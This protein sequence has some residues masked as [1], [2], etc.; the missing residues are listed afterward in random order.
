[1]E[2]T[3]ILLSPVVTEKSNAMQAR[4]TFVFR[5]HLKANKIQVAEAVT[6]AYGVTVEKVQFISVRKKVRLVGR[7]REITKRRAGKKALVTINA[8]QVLDFNKFTKK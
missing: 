5:V 2:L 8:K 1:M 4:H 3:K 7:G 6:K